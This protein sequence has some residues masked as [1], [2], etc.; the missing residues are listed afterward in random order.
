MA[1]SPRLL[2][3]RQTIH[4][5]A[6]AWAAR[7][8]A[9]GGTVGT[10][11][12]AVSSF[13]RAIDAAGIRDRFY[14]LN[15]F[16]GGT[17]GTAVGLNSALVPLYRGPSFGGTQYGN[18]TETNGGGAFVGADYNETGTNGG[19]KGGSSKYLDTTFAQS[20]IALTNVHLSASLRDLET[21]FGGENTIIGHYNSSQS[22]FCTLR[23]AVSTGN[24]DFLAATFGGVNGISAA[25][26]SSESHV[27]GVRYSL[28]SSVLY[29]NGSSIG[30]TSS[31]VGTTASSALSYFVFARNNSGTANNFTAA[32]IRMYSIGLAIT[33]A[34]AAAA[35]ANAV[36]AFNTAMG[37]V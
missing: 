36:A 34:N 4:Q 12:S 15:L 29:R 6:A 27:M 9:N 10:S 8:V 20:N 7:V 21:S 11:L 17:S 22:D 37:R 3:P 32:R 23:Q 30:S 25:G 14:R 26:S 28:T 13:C 31:T 1:Q 18:N 24:R 16:C 35:F 2:R 5:E 19:L 33:D